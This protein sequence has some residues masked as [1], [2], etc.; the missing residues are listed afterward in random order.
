MAP[1][2]DLSQRAAIVTG[3]GSGIGQ[4][5]A[6]L[7]AEAGASVVVVGRNRERLAALAQELRR[8]GHPCGVVRGDVAQEATARRAVAVCVRRFGRVDIL[9][10]NAGTAMMKSAP[11]TSLTEWN[12]VLATNLT[13]VYL[14]SRFAIPEM[15][16]SGGGSV[17]N[18]ASEAGIVGFRRYAAYS[19]SKAAI[20]NLS[21]AMA[22]DHAAKGIRVNSVC[23]GSIETPLLESYYGAFPDPAAEREADAAAHPLGIGQPVDVAWGIL[24]LASDQAR[25]VTG[26]A[27]VIDGG[28]TAQ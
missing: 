6:I 1:A 15:E 27:L 26:H 22:L 21:R 18:V 16:R 2:L 12:R 17:I 4:A 25:Y 24:Y 9:V 5:T 14:F 23:P 11:E 28:F 19:A 7:L 10:N 3:A 8:R 20:V 13:S